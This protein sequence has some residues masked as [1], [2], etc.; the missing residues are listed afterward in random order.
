MT[1]ELDSAAV[2]RYLSE[3][4]GFFEEH[5]ELLANIKLSSVLGG[6]TV[7]LQERQMEILREKYK[8]LELN[9]SNLIRVGEDNDAINLHMQEW[10][11]GLLLV[12]NDADLPQALVAGL[13]TV[14][15]VPHVT[16]R[17]W[18]LSKSLAPAWFTQEVSEDAR[19]FT[20][21]M[22]LPFCGKNQDFEAAGW[23]DDAPEIASLAMLPLR[24]KDHPDAL[25]LLIMGSADPAR[26][27]GEMATDFLA[28]ISDTASAALS[29]L[30]D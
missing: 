28:R 13:R 30:L 11:R 19:I 6:R 20:N 23:F 9:L 1:L 25:G 24:S 12:R 8:A 17:T 2:A 7:S 18:G 3:H 16:L 21:G 10:C 14:F 22:K 5:A 26:F 29:R 15:D 27:T 4:A